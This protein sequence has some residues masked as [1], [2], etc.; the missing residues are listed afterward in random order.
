MRYDSCCWWRLQSTPKTKY[1]NA[2]KQ[3][4][5]FNSSNFSDRALKQWWWWSC[6]WPARRLNESMQGGGRSIYE[7]EKKTLKSNR[8]FLISACGVSCAWWHWVPS[9]LWVV[10]VCAKNASQMMPWRSSRFVLLSHS[11]SHFPIFSF[12]NL[13][14]QL[15]PPSFLTFTF[16]KCFCIVTARSG[17][18][19]QNRNSI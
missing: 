14:R 5:A 1:S 3:K 10:C 15:L 11:H 13:A 12:I 9:Y 18:Q 7:K 8:E 4:I 2:E 16:V 6:W 17:R 19:Q